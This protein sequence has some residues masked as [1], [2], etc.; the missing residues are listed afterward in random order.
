MHAYFPD[1]P[2]GDLQIHRKWHHFS[3]CLSKYYEGRMDSKKSEY[4]WE[5][6]KEDLFDE[7]AR[8]IEEILGS[9]ITGFRVW[10]GLKATGL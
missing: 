6:E 4:E 10:K 7:K 1:R 8:V 3:D 2:K 5:K 9:E